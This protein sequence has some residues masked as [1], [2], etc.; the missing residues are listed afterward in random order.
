V[1]KR[2]AEELRR[3]RRRGLGLAGYERQIQVF[4]LVLVVFLVFANLVSFH[5]LFEAIAEEGRTGRAWAGQEA[6]ALSEEIGE[7]PA[8]VAR[9]AALLRALA[10]RRSLQGLTLLGTDGVRQSSWP[11]LPAGKAD[12]LWERLSPDERRRVRSGFVVQVEQDA[13]PEAPLLST[14][15]PLRA[16]GSRILRVDRAQGLGPLLARRARLFSY[17]YA[18]AVIVSLA[19]VF[20]FTRWVTR[21]YRLLLSRA[22][23]RAGVQPSEPS[24]SVPED[25]IGVFQTILERLQEQERALGALRGA[26]GGGLDEAV[27]NSMGSGVLLANRDGSVRRYNRAAARLLDL[28]EEAGAERVAR[29]LEEVPELTL[30]LRE[31]VE[32]GV[33]APRGLLRLARGPAAPGERHLGV[34]ISPVRGARG[35]V[36]GALC[37]FSDLTE[38]HSLEERA[39]ARDSLAAVGEL[40]A[41]IAHEFRNALHAIDG[42][43]R[44]IE[45]QSG[46][47]PAAAHAAAIRREARE[48]GQVV[49]EFL[50]FARPVRLARQPADLADLLRE[51]GAEAVALYPAV[52]WEVEVPPEECRAEVDSTLLRPA[53]QNLLRN[54]A[55]ALRGRQGGRVRLRLEAP[56]GA[57]EC[58]L[59]VADNGPGIDPRDLP[60]LF[61]PFFTTKERGS[62][63]GLPLARKA[64]LAHDGEIE[65]ESAPGAGSIFRVRLPLSAAGGAQSPRAVE[66]PVSVAPVG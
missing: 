44:L 13:V 29:R 27:I 1:L 18:G 51:V 40:S 3:V 36:E 55:E 34:S 61:T 59:E 31:C 26:G 56:D 64:I 20:L 35:E 45:R 53:L 7:A 19:A 15:V 65:V 5:I 2:L 60:H 33:G 11:S 46:D 50:R 57:A 54:A 39:R 9:D 32:R 38:I 43:A 21:P 47:G 41:G 16:D 37:L 48:T 63:L 42:Y 22:A 49:E 4:L 10:R 23:E 62:G 14:F 25:L 52:R 24:G 66:E 58:R 28:P 8:R 12:P 30:R 17:C 6:V